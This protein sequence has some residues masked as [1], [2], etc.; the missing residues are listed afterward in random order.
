MRFPAACSCPQTQ[1]DALSASASAALATGANLTAQ[2]NG[3][4][5]TASAATGALATELEDI[6]R[7]IA[8]LQ[9]SAAADDAPHDAHRAGAQGDTARGYRANRCR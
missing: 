6:D 5:G 4:L 7:R 3:T 9:V 2:L 8:T 1:A